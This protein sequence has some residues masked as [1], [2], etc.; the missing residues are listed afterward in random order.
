MAHQLTFRVTRNLY[1]MLELPFLA[2]RHLV[3]P[4]LT[5]LVLDPAFLLAG[6]GEVAGPDAVSHLLPQPPRLPFALFLDGQDR[7]LLCLCRDIR[8]LFAGL[9]V[10]R[11]RVPLAFERIQLQSTS[12]QRI[13]HGRFK[14]VR[15]ARKISF[16][17]IFNLKTL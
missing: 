10:L 16:S 15:Q 6:D 5:L 8:E 2:I 3:L 14:G 7:H 17:G 12:K 4:S 13:C 1:E 11:G 9:S